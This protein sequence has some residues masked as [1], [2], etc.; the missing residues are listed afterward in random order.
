MNEAN[1]LA[2]IPTEGDESFNFGE[3]EKE[4]PAESPTEEQ[5][6]VN[7]PAEEGG[8]TPTEEET[9]YKPRTDKR[10]QQLLKE[11]AEE[12]EKREALEER[13]AALEQRNTP[14]EDEDIPEEFVDLFGD[15]LE[16]WKKFDAMTQRQKA[17][18]RQEVINELRAQEEQEAN[19][20]E[21]FAQ[22]YENLMDE[23]EDEGKVFDRNALMKFI[24]ERPIFR[25]DGNPDFATALELMEAAKP[26]ANVQARKQ[27]ASLTPQ[28]K[29]GGKGYVTPDD[30]RGGWGSI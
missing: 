12:R 2:D 20:T 21:Q 7:E 14:Q 22:N 28:G 19:E 3:E 25:Q 13:L 23:L 6:I 1:I 9:D 5:P 15:D 18:W 11:R 16:A 10:I 24:T 30:L 17:A 26:K 8:N 29:V 27:I 4:T